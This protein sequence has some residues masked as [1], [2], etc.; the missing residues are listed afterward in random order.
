VGKVLF[1]AIEFPRDTSWAV[2]QD[3]RLCFTTGGD[4][5]LWNLAN[6]AVVWE[7]GTQGERL[8][9]Q[10]DGNLAIYDAKG[11]CVWATGTSGNHGAYLAAQD[12]GNLVIYSADQSKALWN[13]GT[14]GK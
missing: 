6:K 7:S 3:Y 5:Q 4:L 8:A 9:I 1:Q 14:A 11:T 12:D 13:T 10:A 2:G